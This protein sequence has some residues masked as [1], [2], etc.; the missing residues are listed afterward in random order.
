MR[1]L[2]ACITIG[3]MGYWLLH[4]TYTK[5][6][7]ITADGALFT[8]MNGDLFDFQPYNTLKAAR[9]SFNIHYL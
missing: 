4:Y 2:L 7:D 6:H 9:T 5:H 3:V 1:A 8:C